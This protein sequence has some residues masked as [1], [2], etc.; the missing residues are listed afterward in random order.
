MNNPQ[1]ITRDAPPCVKPSIMFNHLHFYHSK[2]ERNITNNTLIMNARNSKQFHR[3]W[4]KMG[5]KSLSMVVRT[6]NRRCS[7]MPSRNSPAA[8]HANEVCA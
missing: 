4:G 2:S 8:V 3:A 6:Q 7:I 1:N 5:N